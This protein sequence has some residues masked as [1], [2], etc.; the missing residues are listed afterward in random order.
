MKTEKDIE[1]FEKFERKRLEIMQKNQKHFDDFCETIQSYTESLPENE[2]INIYVQL[3]KHGRTFH[4]KFCIVLETAQ[5]NRTKQTIK[6]NGYPTS[7]EEHEIKGD[8]YHYKMI[9]RSFFSVYDE[10]RKACGYSKKAVKKLRSSLNEGK[11]K[12]RQTGKV[13]TG[14]TT[15]RIVNYSE[16]AIAIF[17][18]TKPF[19]D[20]FKEIWGHYNKFLTNE[21]GE[22]TA[23][24]V[25]SKKR[26]EQVKQIINE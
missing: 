25:F 15:V 3:L 8:T 18:N 20:Q 21:E 4:G 9:E 24:W 13:E 11:I 1:I 7:N 10:I 23:G 19:K 16:K 17:G 6:V 2:L 22:R 26:K 14:Q 5:Y 12:S